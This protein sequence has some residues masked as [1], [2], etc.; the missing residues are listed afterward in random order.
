MV[1]LRSFRDVADATFLLAALALALISAALISSTVR[2]HLR[3]YK[4]PALQ[5]CCLRILA[6]APVY[7]VLSWLMMVFLPLAPFIEVF[8]D[9]YETYTLYCYWV[10]L[11][12]WVGGQH[13]VTG[14][15]AEG[16]SSMADCM[17]C[18]LFPAHGLPRA[19]GLTVARFQSAKGHFRY[20]RLALYQLMLTKPSLTLV[21]S[22]LLA[23]Q[24]EGLNRARLLTL[25]S[26]FVGMHAVL[27]T[28][29]CLL[30]H[31]KGLQGSVKFLCIKL[32]VW[33]T[34]FQQMFI[35]AL[36]GYGAIPSE[37]HTHGYNAAERAQRLLSTI[38]IVEM[39]IFRFALP[40]QCFLLVWSLGCHHPLTPFPTCPHN[41]TS[42]CNIAM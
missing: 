13:R 38:T 28:Y 41:H 26:T 37:A 18:P 3:N 12:L 42:A 4:F 6:L 16:G 5:M 27:D 23:L 22:I 15:L 14:V 7:A 9:M 33:V 21:H 34:L 11:V 2:D 32:V 29:S 25:L 19:T 30:P 10:L 20:W 8:R 1:I 31:L 36:L 17:L 39:A 24:M 35:S 40:T